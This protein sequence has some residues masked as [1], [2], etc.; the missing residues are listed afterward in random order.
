MSVGEHREGELPAA[1]PAPFSLDLG[2]PISTSPKAGVGN[3]ETRV[4][5]LI[6]VD[7]TLYVLVNESPDLLRNGH[8]HAQQ[9]VA[10][11]S[12]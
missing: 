2:I 11:H 3:R 6:A 9:V 12:P 1:A 8:V 10:I 7:G 5:D 4:S